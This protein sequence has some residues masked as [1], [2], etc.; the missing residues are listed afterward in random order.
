MESPGTF[1]YSCFHLEHQGDRIND[2]VELS[3]VKGLTAGS[4]LRLIEDPYTE[5]EARMHLIRVR[6]I[7]GA[8]GT[9][10]DTLHGISA[11]LS[12]H[13]NVAPW[14]DPNAPS[15]TSNKATN[16][17]KTE[18]SNALADF[19]FEG[20]PSIQNVLSPNQEQSIKTINCF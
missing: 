1:Q 15:V 20:S 7:I 8:A 5:K 18:K 11:G 2:F 12:L 19:S 16:G 17:Q 14:K 13:D 4:E 3:E 6:E 10:T 9:R